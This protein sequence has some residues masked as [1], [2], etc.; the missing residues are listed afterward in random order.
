MR[1]LPNNEIVEIFFFNLLKCY[2]LRIACFSIA[3]G[4]RTQGI[5]NDATDRIIGVPITDND[6]LPEIVV[7]FI[8]EKNPILTLVNFSFIGTAR[9]ITKHIDIELLLTFFLSV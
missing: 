7:R 2:F 4:N 3:A 6:H 5:L 9:L 8:L 1:N